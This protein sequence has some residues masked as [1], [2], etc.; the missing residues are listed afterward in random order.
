MLDRERLRSVKVVPTRTPRRVL[1]LTC[2]LPSLF[3]LHKT[4]FHRPSFQAR[5]SAVDETSTSV[6]AKHRGAVLRS[7]PLVL[8]RVDAAD[9]AQ[10]TRGE[11]GVVLAM[12]TIFVVVVV[13]ILVVGDAA[14]GPGRVDSVNRRFT[15]AINI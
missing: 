14:A 4:P 5:P 6:L 2:G 12:G 15:S 9:A 13:V 7:P 1:F 10:A 8:R 3:R 11:A